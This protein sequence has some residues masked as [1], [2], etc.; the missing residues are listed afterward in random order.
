MGASQQIRALQ[1]AFGLGCMLVASL[2]WP[3]AMAQE[4]PTTETPESLAGA[5]PGDA[6]SVDSA[7]GSASTENPITR[8]EAQ[9]EFTQLMS[10]GRFD[11]A[12]DLGETMLLL[13]EEEFG[14]NSVEAAEANYQLA[15][16]QRRAKRHEAA[17]TTY[18]RS[19][20]IYR[21]NEGPFTGSLI[22]PT[23]GLGDNYQDD[24][25]YL[26]AVSSYNEARTIQ[27]RV[28]GLLSERQIELFDRMSESFEQM[29]NHTEAN[30]QQE[31]ALM[32]VERNNPPDSIEVL[33]AI[34]RYARW[35]RST[36][37]FTE[38]RLQ[39]DR[40]IRIIRESYGKDSPL[41]VTPYREI[42]NSFRSQAYPE[43]RGI[44]SINTAIELLEL[45]GEPDPLEY[46]RTYLSLGD[47]RTAFGTVDTGEAEYL[48]SW[49]LLANV[50][51]GDE[52]RSQWF[53][54]RRPIFVLTRYISDRGLSRE[55]GATAGSV[56]VRFDI[57][58]VGRA[59]NVSVVESDPPGFK[60]DA[61]VRA[62][63][64]SRFRPHISD[65][66]LVAAENLG[67]EFSFRYLPEDANEETK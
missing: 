54:S 47:W 60:D 1:R 44:G 9:I 61:A 17:E 38:E 8:F 27:R 34:Y 62:I 23:I 18:L 14:W 37:R 26:N 49:E 30:Q 20:E 48:R 36:F 15:E 40:A 24:G 13:T 7:D 4:P 59:Q 22:E 43:N 65:G 46:A 3:V 50:E 52:W 51:D 29:G 42:G 57:D 66:A 31:N 45:Q 25:Q 64:Q 41:L 6:I 12:A 63:L 35:L 55:P 58:S 21:M 67:V 53:G 16:A 2:W 56:L 33:E 5:D 39:Y 11:E 32:L 10:D 19:I 28:Y